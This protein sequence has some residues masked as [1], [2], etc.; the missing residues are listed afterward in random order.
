[1]LSYVFVAHCSYQRLKQVCRQRGRAALLQGACFLLHKADGSTQHVLLYLTHSGS[2]RGGQPSRLGRQ[3]QPESGITLVL[4]ALPETRGEARVAYRRM[5]AGTADA[6]GAA[7]AGDAS[8]HSAHSAAGAAAGSTAGGVGLGSTP[9][10]PTGR[11]LGSVGAGIRLRMQRGTM[12]Q[13]GYDSGKFPRSAL[14]VLKAVPANQLVGVVRG[15]TH[16]ASPANGSSSAGGGLAGSAAECFT[17]MVQEDNSGYVTAINLQLPPVG[18]GRNLDEWILAVRDVAAAVQPAAAGPA[19]VTVP[20][21]QAA[22]AA[23]AS[24]AADAYAG[25]QAQPLHIAV[26]ERL[27]QGEVL[28]AGPATTVAG[29]GAVPVASTGDGVDSMLQ[30]GQAPEG[31]EPVAAPHKVVA[32]AVASADAGGTAAFDSSASPGALTDSPV[33]REDSNAHHALEARDWLLP[34]AASATPKPFAPQ[35]S[36]AVSIGGASRD[37]SS[38]DDTDTDDV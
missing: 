26:A 11:L 29:A 21:T 34:A 16:F 24:Q 37:S 23:V 38:E 8:S 12:L 3:Q 9:P 6:A 10:T 5:A 18:N 25:A 31:S 19:V 33:Y 15:S 1:M 22:V 13:L 30:L 27:E 17:L 7:G 14:Q 20:A 36:A 2:S 35:P 28:S 4:A 32:H